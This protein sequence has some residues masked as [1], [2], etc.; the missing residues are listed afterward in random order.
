[1]TYPTRGG[2]YVRDAVTDELMPVGK[3]DPAPAEVPVEPTA[4][5]EIKAVKKTAKKE[6]N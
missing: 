5:S 3:A 6:G 2:R 4:P 1:M